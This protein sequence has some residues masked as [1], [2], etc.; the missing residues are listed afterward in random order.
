MEAEQ[1][2]GRRG[3]G[4]NSENAQVWEIESWLCVFLI[5]ES[6]WFQK[7]F[8]VAA[9]LKQGCEKIVAEE[10]NALLEPERPR[11]RSTW[12]EGGR[13]YQEEVGHCSSP[14]CRIC[15]LLP[16]QVAKIKLE[17]LLQILNFQGQQG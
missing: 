6:L 7:F 1:R 4:A 12:S 3:L 11:P 9:H 2:R 14:D 15:G 5:Q 10:W 17:S 13:Q 8:Q 16:W